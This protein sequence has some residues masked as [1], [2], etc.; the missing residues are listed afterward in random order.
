MEAVA[1]SFGSVAALTDVTFT[2]RRG[3]LFGLLGPNGAGKTTLLKLLS[4]L[5]SP[6]RG[7]ILLDG[8]DV[9]RNAEAAKRRIGLC[10]SEERSFYARLSARANMEYFGALVGLSGSRLRGRIVEVARVVGLDDVLDRRF[11][12]FSSGMRQRLTV[13]RALLADPPILIFDEPT[14]AVDPVNAEAIRVLIRDDLVSRRHKTVILATNLLHEAWTMCDRIAVLNRGRVVALDQPA[15]LS[16][17]FQAVAR[18][19]LEFAPH[20]Q[21]FVQRLRD[22]PGTRVAAVRATPLGCEVDLD[23]DRGEA[24]LRAVMALLAGAEVQIK[25]FRSIEPDPVEV[26]QHVTG[27]GGR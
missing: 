15:A 11:E 13:A 8:F 17:S 24:S 7:R 27:A 19:Q 18:Y 23:L 1:K 12:G 26:F 4:T 5:L 25:E 2:V 14:R 22:L 6:D 20:D 21:A 3:E 16:A 10:P 9:L